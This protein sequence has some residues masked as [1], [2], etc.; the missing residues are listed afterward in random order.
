MDLAQQVREA[1]K[2][3]G[4]T[5][6]QLAVQAGVHPATIHRL[7]TGHYDTKPAVRVKLEAVLGVTLTREH[8]TR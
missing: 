5:Q 4:L 6:V 2:A 7:E 8:V 1:R 3:L